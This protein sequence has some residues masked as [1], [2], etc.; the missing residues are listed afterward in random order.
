MPQM[1]NATNARKK[2]SSHTALQ[3][4]FPQLQSRGSR[5]LFIPVAVHARMDLTI[6]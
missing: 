1:P 2:V 4:N 5:E 3:A 6:F